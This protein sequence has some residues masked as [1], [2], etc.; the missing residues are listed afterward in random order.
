MRE[1]GRLRKPGSLGEVPGAACRNAYRG[2]GVT[3]EELISPRKLQMPVSKLRFRV[4]TSYFM[5]P[6]AS[7]D[8]AVTLEADK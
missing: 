8:D 6:D 7:K 1:G 2:G 3:I 4:S 5:R